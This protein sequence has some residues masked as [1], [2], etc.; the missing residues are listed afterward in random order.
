MP[1]AETESR[2][3]AYFDGELDALAAAAFEAHLET[4]AE[5]RAAL[6]GLEAM[7]SAL[8]AEL[9]YERA[10]AELAARVTAALDREASAAAAQKQGP[11]DEL[12]GDPLAALTTLAARGRAARAGRPA[13]G[14]STPSFGRGCS[15][16]RVAG[17]SRRSWPFFSFL[18]TSFPRAPRCSTISSMRTSARFCLRISSM[19]NRR[20]GTP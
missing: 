9:P 13:R 15:P 12:M 14:Q 18:R 3:H 5:C 19:W 8:R 7:R 11:E 2:L 20:T 10:P 17:C 6:E 1:C 4:C 16:V